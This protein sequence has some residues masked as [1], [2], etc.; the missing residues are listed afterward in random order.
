MNKQLYTSKN[1]FTLA[2]MMV[3]LVIASIITLIL[4][5]SYTSQ[6]SIFTFQSW[7]SKSVEEGRSVFLLLHQLIRH[8]EKDSFSIVENETE[9]TIDFSL[10]EGQ[11]IWPNL[12]PPYSD[13][14]I[15]IQWKKHHN[16]YH[17]LSIANHD[18]QEELKAVNLTPLIGYPAIDNTDIKQFSLIPTTRGF[19]LSLASGIG[20]SETYHS[21]IGFEAHVTPRN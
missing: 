5:S 13:R 9:T 18:H 19:I 4:I 20:Q 14:Y 10:P 8:A 17:T 11:V 1:G 2:E 3:S 16:D 6:A 15:R 21:K 7:R 12:N